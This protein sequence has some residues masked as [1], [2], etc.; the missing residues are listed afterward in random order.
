MTLRKPKLQ[1]LVVDFEVG[2]SLQREQMDS[3]RTDV[4]VHLK[5]QLKNAKLEL[6]IHV[7][8]QDLEDRKAFLSDRDRY[9]LMVQKN[10]A[11]DALRQALD[12]DL[13]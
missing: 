8:E 3:L 13:G 6:Q 12:L 9:D 5:S 2:N 7:V 11:L 4:L 10:P 1:G